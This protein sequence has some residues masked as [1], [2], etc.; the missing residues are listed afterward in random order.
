VK[1]AKPKPREPLF[2]IMFKLRSLPAADQCAY[3]IACIKAEHPDSSRRRELH[4]LLVDRRTN[5]IQ[6]EMKKPDQRRRKA[7]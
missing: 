5:Q 4:K 7:S 6:D 3:V 2:R 1:R